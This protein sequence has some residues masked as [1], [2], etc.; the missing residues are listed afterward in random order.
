MKKT[1][2]SSEY[3]QALVLFV[4]GIAI[5]TGFVALAIDGGMLLSD[6]RQAQ[7]AADSAAMAAALARM[8]NQN[9]QTAGLTAAAAFDYDNDGTE[10]WVSVHNPPLT[11]LYATVPNA[12]QYLQ[13]FITST[14]KTSFA[15]IV[16]N[17]LTQNT[18]MAVA[19]AR[20]TQ[21]LSP[22]NALHATNPNA[23]NA[24]TFSG[25]SGT[26]VTGG[27]A[28]SNSTA[29][30]SPTSCHSIRKNGSTGD[31]D[32]NGGGILAAGTFRNITGDGVTT[33][34][35]I[36][37]YQDQ[38][39]I[40]PIPNPDCSNLP[41]RSYNGG[42]VTL[43]PGIYDD[44]LRIT[45]FHDNVTLSPGL[46]CLRDDF[47]ATGG[48]L[49]GDEVMIYMEEGAIEI[50]G[51]VSVNLTRS[52]DLVDASGNQWAGMIVYMP[53]ENTSLIDMNGNSGSIYTG[54]IFAP[55]LASPAS[56]PKCS[57]GGNGDSIAFNAQ[58]ICNTVE[59]YGNGTLY[60]TFNEEDNY[61][62]PPIIEL[63]E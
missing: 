6:R 2:H 32:I 53:P 13:V 14:L 38:Q 11:G 51:N 41:H 28:F 63:V 10:N 24:M 27:N 25:S 18:V 61:R 45:N 20:P 55:G 49:T 52:S 12:N 8:S 26:I 35:G 50:R 9:W 16:F 39:D 54:T 60:I 43:L 21:T 23:C 29:H 3:G 15:Q 37:E 19:R 17:N 31:V 47:S 44:G 42:E 46:Y 58:V 30:G 57:V 33:D 4:V 22:G 40:P 7:N 34:D 59:M 36:H 1:S 5:F 62:L 48:V 56:Q